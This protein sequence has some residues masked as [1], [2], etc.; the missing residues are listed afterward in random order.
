[1]SPAVARVF[2]PEAFD[3]ATR[4]IARVKAEQI[5]LRRGVN[6]ARDETKQVRDMV[7]GPLTDHSAAIRALTTSVDGLAQATDGV[8]ARLSDLTAASRSRD[9]AVWRSISELSSKIETSAS[10]EVARNAWLNEQH[11]QLRQDAQKAV[12]EVMLQALT[13]GSTA[14]AAH[15]QVAAAHRQL[16]AFSEKVDEVDERVEKVD[17]KIEDVDDRVD[18]VKEATDT[19]AQKIEKRLGMA[20]LVVVILEKLLTHLL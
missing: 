13:A 10:N 11:Q 4:D 14:E 15:A 17:G 2:D 19:L 1:M 6:V 18:D 3:S 12:A 8:S 5:D 20:A 7:V 16:E 9:D